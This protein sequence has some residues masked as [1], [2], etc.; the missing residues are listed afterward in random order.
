VV[1]DDEARR[2]KRAFLGK[3]RGT[4]KGNGKFFGHNFLQLPK[5]G[6]TRFQS[7]KIVLTFTSNLTIGALSMGL[8]L[9]AGMG[10]NCICDHS[11]VRS[12]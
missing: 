6:E 3:K 2:N 11:H 1:N 8:S 4:T 10:N 12:L 7:Q 9:L 5:T